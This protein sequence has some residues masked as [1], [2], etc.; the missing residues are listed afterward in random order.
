MNSCK[1]HK[2]YK[3]IKKPISTKKH[4]GGCETCWKVYAANKKNV[5]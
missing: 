2:K 1:E 4:P 5:N 3:A